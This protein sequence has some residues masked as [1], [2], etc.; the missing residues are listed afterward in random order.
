MHHRFQFRRCEGAVLS[1][2]RKQ[3]H[4]CS[5]SL[6]N[7]LEPDG[8][9]GEEN[10]SGEKCEHRALVVFVRCM[11]FVKGSSTAAN[12][13]SPA[14]NTKDAIPR[15]GGAARNPKYASIAP[16]VQN[17]MKDADSQRRVARG[18]LFA[19]KDAMEAYPSGTSARIWPEAST[20][21]SD[22]DTAEPAPSTSPSLARSNATAM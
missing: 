5:S 14:A 19:L 22:K 7:L 18:T 3:V 9:Q 21:P 15:Y 12:V 16:V 17:V 1:T 20:R 11:R 10:E 4:R 13:S 2:R 6:D 8:H